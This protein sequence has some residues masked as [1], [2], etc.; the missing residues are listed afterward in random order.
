M[1][2]WRWGASLAVL[3]LASS[4]AISAQD[5]GAYKSQA[6][7]ATASRLAHAG[8]PA[9]MLRLGEMLRYGEVK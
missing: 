1:K 9:G 7:P 4:S 3:L 5:K 6:D 2:L 8:E